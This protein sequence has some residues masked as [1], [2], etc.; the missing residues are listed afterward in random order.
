MAKKFIEREDKR[1]SQKVRQDALGKIRSRLNSGSTFNTEVFR[2]LRNNEEIEDNYNFL[3]F[4]D[5]FEEAE[6]AIVRGEIFD[7]DIKNNF[8]DEL[9]FSCKY[10]MN[11]LE[12]VSGHGGFKSLCN[13][14][15]NL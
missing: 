9:L 13:R 2:K 4:I 1:E 5:P 3:R 8:G 7:I 11:F 6:E 10:R 15:F 12:N 14:I